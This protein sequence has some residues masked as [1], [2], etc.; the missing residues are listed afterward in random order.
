MGLERSC[1]FLVLILRK[2]MIKNVKKLIGIAVKSLKT[3][4]KRLHQ[5]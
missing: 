4:H 5:Y 3:I 1:V 2:D